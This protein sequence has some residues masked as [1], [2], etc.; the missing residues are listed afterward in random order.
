MAGVLAKVNSAIE[1][2]RLRE[3]DKRLLIPFGSVLIHADHLAPTARSQHFEILLPNP[4]EAPFILSVRCLSPR[5][6][7]QILGNDNV[8]S[9]NLRLRRLAALSLDL[10]V[11]AVEA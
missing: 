7:V 4:K 2:T 6:I 1:A 9:E 3:C 11:Q 5:R 10:F 8:G